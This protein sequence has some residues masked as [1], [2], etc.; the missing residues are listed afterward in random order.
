M[1]VKE[2]KLNKRDKA[3]LL[4]DRVMTA[5]ELRESK[6]GLVSVGSHGVRHIQL[7]CLREDEAKRELVE[8]KQQLE[9]ILGLAIAGFS[10]PRGEYNHRVVQWAREAGYE[11]VFTIEPK[12]ALEDPEEY[13]TGRFTVEPSDWRLEFRLKLLGAYRWLPA[14]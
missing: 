3:Q 10:F 11:R 7:S 5:E 13:V 9:S 8:S 14:A 1:R 12:L 2:I 4:D 6:G